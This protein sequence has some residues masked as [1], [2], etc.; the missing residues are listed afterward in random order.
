M[1]ERNI[2]SPSPPSIDKHAACLLAV[3]LPFQTS[4]AASGNIA[5]DVALDREVGSIR[6]VLQRNPQNRLDVLVSHGVGALTLLRGLDSQG[7]ALFLE[8]GHVVAAR[9]VVDAESAVGAGPSAREGRA[10]APVGG[11]AHGGLGEAGWIAGG[12]IRRRWGPGDARAVLEPCRRGI[13]AG[14]NSQAR[15]DG[16]GLHGGKCCLD[17]CL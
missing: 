5:L 15:D 13:H 7:A 10:E 16:E 14:S 8:D 4:P 12:L 6:V 17:L 9:H 3:D 11:I 1:A 2:Q